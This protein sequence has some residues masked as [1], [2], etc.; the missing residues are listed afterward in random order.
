MCTRTDE[1][2]VAE[3]PPDEQI[4]DV[5]AWESIEHNPPPA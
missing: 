3:P 4:D 5:P 1:V 2:P